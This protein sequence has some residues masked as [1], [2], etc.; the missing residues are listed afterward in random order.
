MSAHKKQKTTHTVVGHSSVKVSE[1]I[2]FDM[3]EKMVSVPTC[4]YSGKKTMQ[5]S[6]TIYS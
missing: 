5:K 3:E 2:T 1:K 6:Y 4:F